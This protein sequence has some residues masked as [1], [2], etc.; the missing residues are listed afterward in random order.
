MCFPVTDAVPADSVSSC[1]GPTASSPAA[2]LAVSSAQEAPLGSSVL[3]DGAREPA[4]GGALINATPRALQQVEEMSPAIASSAH[5]ASDI[6]GADSSPW[7]SPA[8]GLVVQMRDEWDAS[9]SLS[10]SLGC[11]LAGP[12]RAHGLSGIM[13]LSA[14]QAQEAEPTNLSTLTPAGA[15][16]G[17]NVA[18]VRGENL[19]RGSLGSVFKAL[20]SRT[21]QI[22]AVKEVCI[23]S[24]LGSDLKLK[25]AL[26]GEVEI[27]RELQHPHIV[28]Y[29]GHDEIGTSLYIYLEYMP[30]G[31]VAQ[32]L[33]Q[34]GAFDESLIRTHARG[35]LEGL[36]YLHTRH[37]LVLHR[38]IK[39][40]NILVGLNGEVKLADFGCSKR[41]VDT[42]MQTRGMAVG[43][44][45]W[46]A[47]EVIQQTG[48]GRRS[49]I[50]S[51]GCVIIEMATA[52]QPWGG[53]FDNHIAA[54]FRIMRSEATPQPPEC[55]SEG[56]RDF[57][58]QC[59]QRDKNLRP[60]ASALLQHDFVRDV[61]VLVESEA[62]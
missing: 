26:E 12:E 34:Y 56:C 30:G 48:Y 40:A 29:L 2:S 49:D 23:D 54:A 32:V 28:S 58:R 57:I 1:P 27:Y 59:T 14:S 3:V 18:W 16:R 60:L 53:A 21:G 45:P 50:W 6:A 10:Q 8:S 47:P 41:T 31:S 25:K 36:E 62:H 55:L 20:D 9:T 44:V 5:A 13:G 61:Q 38:D 24:K 46:M 7:V 51:F 22:F 52:K 19:G 42:M 43:S 11:Q 39:G 35:V 17:S 15:V 37:P 4:V 33:S